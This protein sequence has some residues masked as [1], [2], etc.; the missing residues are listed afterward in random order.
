MPLQIGNAEAIGTIK[1]LQLD[2]KQFFAKKKT[3]IS[4]EDFFVLNIFFSL[5]VCYR[6]VWVE[7]RVPSS[8]K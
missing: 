6:F 3:Y 7:I 4:Y 2:K 1:C 5:S 8:Y